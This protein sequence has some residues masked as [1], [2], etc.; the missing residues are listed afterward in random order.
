MANMS[1]EELVEIEQHNLVLEQEPNT[2]DDNYKLSGVRLI[3]FKQLLETLK[4]VSNHDPILKCNITNLNIIGNK[5]MGLITKFKLQ[6]N[7][8][9]RTFIV[10]STDDKNDN[11]LNIN[12]AAVTGI[13]AAGIGYSQLQEITSSIGLPIFG[14]KMYA[15]LHDQIC[16][17]WEN[18]ATQSMEEAAARE[19]QAAIDEGR[20]VN[21]IPVIDVYLDGCWAKRSY[22][23]N[24]RASSGAAAIIGR[25]F[26]QVI[27]MA[28]KNKYCVICKRA[29]NKGVLPQEHKCYKNYDGPS[30]AIEGDIVLEGFKKSISMYNLIFGRIIADGDCDIFQNFRSATL[31]QFCR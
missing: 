28:V 13:M 5:T 9:N 24:F 22:G 10:S 7:L 16:D 4:K 1:L 15:K 11:E 14:E 26:G 8:C 25:R 12:L 30:T 29:E 2:I 17:E 18:A 19:R 3:E 27:F 23:N 31:W 6:C 21:G 20:I